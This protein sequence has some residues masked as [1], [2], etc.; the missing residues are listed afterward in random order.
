[1]ITIMIIDDHPLVKEGMASMLE[2][3]EDFSVVKVASNGK[4]AI[5]FC[6]THELPDVIVS[7]IRMPGMDG[8]ETLARLQHSFPNVRMLM[9]AGMPLKAEEGRARAAKACG[10]LPKTIDWERLVSAIRLSAKEGTFLSESFDEETNGPLSPREKEILFYISQGKTHEEIGIILGI[11]S[12]TVR[13]HTKSIQR[14]L[15]CTNS[16]SSVTRAFELGIL[17]A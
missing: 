5:D 8:F 12:E 4:E 16:A 13:T 14:K 10:Y 15:D 7:D 6:R 17:R 3:E 2:N 1:M 11:S 9:L